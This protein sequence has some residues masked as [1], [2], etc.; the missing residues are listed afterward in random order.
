[1][2]SLKDTGVHVYHFMMLV[3]GSDASENAEFA[4]K[5]FPM[6]RSHAAGEYVEDKS[7][8]PCAPM[9][10]PA[11]FLLQ[12]VRVSRQDSTEPPCNPAIPAVGDEL[13]QAAVR[14]TM[15]GVP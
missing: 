7:C 9:D 11:F 4:K 2:V 5:G 3:G 14:V 13:R 1:M 12:A 6:D 8:C 10:G 15:T